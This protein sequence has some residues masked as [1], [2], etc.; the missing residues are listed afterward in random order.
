MEKLRKISVLLLFFSLKS[1]ASQTLYFPPVS[2]T[3]W[4]TLAPNRLGWC[5]DKIDSLDAY[6]AQNGTKAFIYLKDG[7][8]VLERY[9]GGHSASSNWYWAS[10]GKTLTAFLTGIAVQEGKI[11][12]NDTTSKYL[13]AGWTNCSVAEEARINIRHQLTMT[14]GLDDQIA[15][16]YCTLDTCLNCLAAPGSR[17]AYHNGPYTL[18]DPVLEKATGVTLNQWCNTKLKVLTGMNGSFLPSGYNNVFFSTARSMARFGLLL[19][20]RGNWDIIRVLSDTA[21][22]RQ[23]TNSSQ[24]LNPAYGYLTWL[25]GKK[26]YRLPE[27]QVL[28]PGPLFPDAPSDVYAALGKD[29]QFINV[30]PSQNAVWIRMGNASQNVQVPFLLNN[31]IW[32]RINALKCFGQQATQQAPSLLR[33]Y[34]NPAFSQVRIESPEAETEVSIYDVSGKRV[35]GPKQFRQTLITLDISGLP[36]GCFYAELKGKQGSYRGMINKVTY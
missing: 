17:W 20:S 29:G 25:N 32:K 5:S 22:F 33:M 7:K 11:R 28:F 15:D 10:A 18:L 4:D 19:L 27:S 24:S 31:E 35:Y 6:L 13:G 16:P 36:A 14:S 1:L 3:S 2:G 26:S 9:F 21:Y 34:P 23:M 12:L 8:I 30:I